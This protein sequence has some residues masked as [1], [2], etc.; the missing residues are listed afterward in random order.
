MFRAVVEDTASNGL[1]HPFLGMLACGR[2][3]IVGAS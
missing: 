2:Q 1:D 3:V